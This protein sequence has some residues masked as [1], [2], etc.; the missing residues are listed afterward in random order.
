MF[1]ACVDQIKLD[2]PAGFSNSIVI[3]GKLSKADVTS[4]RVRI[5]DLFNFDGAAKFFYVYRVILLDELGHNIEIP[6]IGIDVYFKILDKEFSVD[7]G[8]S[9][10]LRVELED[11]SIIESDFS[12][13]KPLEKNNSLRYELVSKSATNESGEDIINDYIQYYYK[14][15]FSSNSEIKYRHDIS[16][17]FKFTDYYPPDQIGGVNAQR[18]PI[19]ASNKKST[20][21]VTDNRDL[22]NLKL[23]DQNLFS[24]IADQNNSY[25][26][27]I[28]EEIV[29]WTYAEDY[30]LTI[31][32]ESLDQKT[33]DYYDQISSVVSFTG[34]MF[35]PIP[36]QVKSNMG[37]VNGSNEDVFG[38]FYAS[39]VDTTRLF[40]PR[41]QVGRPDTLCLRPVP[42]ISSGSILVPDQTCF[43][44]TYACCDCLSWENS[45]LEKPSFWK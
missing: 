36:S 33:F 38:Y 26:T 40:V 1:S 14:T 27:M 16:R 7:Y 25:E 8:S 6:L 4:I 44:I 43:W 31:I 19:P 30:N 18:V 45:T 12:E 3:D 42:A 34:G 39:D 13:L 17:T 21:Y 29:D 22:L 28:Y 5:S 15:Q 32:Q 10:Q 9:Y 23:I 20:C 35:E 37:Y 24:E 11:G 2:P 41:Q